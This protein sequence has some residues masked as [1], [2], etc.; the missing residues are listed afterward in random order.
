MLFIFSLRW[1][2]KLDYFGARYYSSMI[3]RWLTPDPLADQYPGWS[4]SN[5]VLGNPL[6]FID[7]DGR[8]VKAVVNGTTVY[9]R[10]TSW[11]VDVN[12]T[13]SKIPIIGAYF[14]AERVLR[15]DP[16]FRPNL[17][18]YFMFAYTQVANLS[19][20]SYGLRSLGFAN[21]AVINFATMELTKDQEIEIL[22]E[23]LAFNQLVKKGEAV[24]VTYV[25]GNPVATKYDT[26]I[27]MMNP[28]IRIM[29]LK[30][31]PLSES[32]IDAEFQ[33]LLDEMIESYR[34]KRD[35][36]SYRGSGFWRPASEQ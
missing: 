13:F 24:Y 20:A 17:G 31:N 12:L 7:P 2:L 14:F 23:R 36:E 19:T 29:L 3:G 10:W 30:M 6:R 27:I 21:E 1:N 28:K 9:R 34:E 18:D 35:D 11:D 22:A 8:Y 33:K 5:Y 15:N 25:D 32:Q 4:P 16:S 26:G